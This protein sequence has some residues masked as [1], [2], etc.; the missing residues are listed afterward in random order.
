MKT[1][2]R[3]HTHTPFV[4]GEY[5]NASHCYPSNVNE[6]INRCAG[7]DFAEVCYS[8]NRKSCWLGQ[9]GFKAVGGGR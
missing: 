5:E 7:K 9:R 6:S 8:G 2:L 1:P 4:I 3:A